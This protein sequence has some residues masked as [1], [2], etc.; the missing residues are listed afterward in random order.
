MDARGFV[1]GRLWVVPDVGTRLTWQCRLGKEGSVP[2][3]PGSPNLCR[4]S[5]GVTTEG[6]CCLGDGCRSGLRPRSLTLFQENALGERRLL[7]LGMKRVCESGGER[8]CS[9]LAPGNMKMP[10]P[11]A[12]AGG[13]W[14]VRKGTVMSPALPI[15]CLAKAS[16]DLPRTALQALSGI[17]ACVRHPSRLFPVRRSTRDPL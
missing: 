5:P 4:P 3:A 17:P 11:G 8:G 6:W 13:S 12:R 7:R 14:Q 16:A 1:E 2:R 10:L 15:C 9:R